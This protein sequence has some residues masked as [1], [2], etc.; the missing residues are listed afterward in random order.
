[1]CAAI[2]FLE[3]PIKFTSPIITK[4]AAFDVGMRVFDALNKVEWFLLVFSHLMVFRPGFAK[5][6]W[7]LRA[8]SAILIIQT[9]WLLPILNEKVIHFIESGKM[10]SS[11]HHSLYIGLEALKMAI[12]LF[13]GIQG[14][15]IY[16]N[17]D[18]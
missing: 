5:L 11:Y 6:K 10:I 15:K 18:Y 3:A 17:E 16:K 7:I 9:I 4:K 14:L 13:I 12:L 1:M 2:G 8:V